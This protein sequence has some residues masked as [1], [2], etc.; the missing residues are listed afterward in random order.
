MEE[1]LER[2]R[3][4]IALHVAALVDDGEPVPEEQEHPQLL[5]VT[6]PA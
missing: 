2:A 4:A 6:I 1:C 3:E 5:T